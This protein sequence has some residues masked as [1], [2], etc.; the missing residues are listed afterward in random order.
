MTCA[1]LVLTACGGRADS[2][3][4]SADGG[5]CDPGITDSTIRIGSSLPMSGAGAVY[6]SIGRAAQAYFEDLNAAGGVEMGDGV[7]RTVEYRAMDDAYDP[8]RTVSNTRT[9]VEQDQ[10]FAMMNVLGT[11]PNLAIGDYVAGNG[12][13]NLFAMTGTDEFMAQDE[14]WSMGFLPQYEFEAQVMADYVLEQNPQ[15]KVGLLYQNDGFGKGMLANFQREFEGTGVE[16]VSEQA[17]EQSGGSADSQV[18][19]LAN[20]GA[21]VWLNYATGTF[22]TQSLKKAHEI[23][24]QPLTLVTSGTNHAQAVMQPAGEGAVDAVSFTW[25]KDVSDPGWAE[26][27][28]MQA[29]QAFAEKH[30]GDFE[31]ADSTA[32]NGYTVAQ[33]MVEVLE[34]MEGC[35][36]QDMLDAA[37]NLSG[38]APDLFLP[39]VTM[40]TSPD[41]PY[42]T[43]QVQMMTFDG[44]TWELQ[45]D[46][47]E[48]SR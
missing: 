19:N 24:W 32:A 45:G 46:V 13:P 41:Y 9:L 22:M 34:Q 4:A 33:A 27:E 20:S 1:A 44:T 10:V 21:D 37:Q 3:A 18:V 25:L 28:G 36:R 26:D 35:T 38:V 43:T 2:T 8:A 23:G 6:G 17:Y 15:A 11:S 16:I 47:I 30:G 39:G 14:Y 29:W 48:R 40:E 42:T 12:V 5:E 31:A 7:T